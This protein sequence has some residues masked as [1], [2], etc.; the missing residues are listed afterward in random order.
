MEIATTGDAVDFGD[1]SVG[2]QNLD[3]SAG[4]TRGC[5]AGGSGNSGGDVIDYITIATLG[6]ATDFGNLSVSRSYIA[7]QVS[8]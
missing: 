8:A 4:H 1:L 7:G 5:F 6:N 3:G 2:R